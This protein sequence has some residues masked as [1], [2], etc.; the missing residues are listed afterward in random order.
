[1]TGK[2]RAT[3]W[4]SSEAPDTDFTAKLVDVYPDGYS[5]I[6]AD[7][8]IRTRYRNGQDRS[9][10][11][12]PGRVYQV[13]IDMNSASNL[14]GKGHRIRLDV[15]SSN[16]PKFEPNPNTGEPAGAWTRRVK[17]KNTVY[18]DEKRPSHVELPVVR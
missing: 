8:Q 18:L 7:G 1:M 3:L 13:S 11:M 10:L 15:S 2:I 12:Q 4:I 16:Y 5:A 14:F 9:Q 6:I 17:P